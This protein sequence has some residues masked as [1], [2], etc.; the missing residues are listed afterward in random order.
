MLFD[1]LVNT[2]PDFQNHLE[3]N[4]KKSTRATLKQYLEAQAEK[5]YTE[6]FN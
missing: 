6:L 3:Y 5:P 2:S 4:R 1:D